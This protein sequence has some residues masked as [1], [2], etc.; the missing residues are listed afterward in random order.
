MLHLFWCFSKW[1]HLRC[2]LLFSFK[3]NSLSSQSWSCANCC[4]SA[5]PGGPKPS[6]T[7]T[8]SPACDLFTRQHEYSTAQSVPSDYTSVNATFP[9]HS[10]LQTFHLP[11]A[12]F[13]SPLSAFSKPTYHSGC[14]S[15]PSAPASPPG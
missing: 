2:T 5:S 15:T 4:I 7:G 9:H 1:V 14:S 13:V 6:N 3:F 8:S 10:Y 12:H 11:S